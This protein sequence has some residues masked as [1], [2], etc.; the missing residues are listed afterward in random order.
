MTDLSRIMSEVFKEMSPIIEKSA[1]HNNSFFN[2]EQLD[3][4]IRQANVLMANKIIAQ[5]EEKVKIMKERIRQLNTS[6]NEIDIVIGGY[7]YDAITIIDE[8]YKKLAG[9]MK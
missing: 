3:N 4:L 8:E 1:V 6:N 7:I 5:V 2:L 9:L